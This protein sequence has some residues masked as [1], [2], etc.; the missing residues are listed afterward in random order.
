MNESILVRYIRMLIAEE[1]N[2][3]VPNQLIDPED[4]GKEDEAQE[5]VNEF[6]GAGG[7][8]NSVGSG[9]IMGYSGPLGSGSKKKNK[10]NKR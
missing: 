1:H 7:G 4:A 2:A 6:C 9:N 8:G 3:R 5:D 10:K